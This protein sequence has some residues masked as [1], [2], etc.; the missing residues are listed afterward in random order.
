MALLGNDAARKNQQEGINF[1]SHMISLK[2]QVR[3]FSPRGKPAFDSL[4]G[5]SLLSLVVQGAGLVP[6]TDLTAPLSPCSVT[7][8]CVTKTLSSSTQTHMSTFWAH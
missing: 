4:T 7:D 8:Q 6:H 3:E 5:E 2:W 1:V